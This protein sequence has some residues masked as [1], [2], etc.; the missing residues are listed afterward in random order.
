MK[1]AQHAIALKATSEALQ[2]RD[3][4]HS[5]RF[6]RNKARRASQ[7]HRVR[8]IRDPGAARTT[9]AIHLPRRLWRDQ[10]LQTRRAYPAGLSEGRVRRERPRETPPYVKEKPPG[11][12][13]GFSSFFEEKQAP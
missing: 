2:G 4:Q 3:P 8:F 5:R 6:V 13:E 1:G 10:L 12:A 11:L 7:A 9:Q